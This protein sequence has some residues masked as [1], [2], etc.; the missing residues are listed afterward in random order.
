MNEFAE[1]IDV[2]VA[3][4]VAFSALSDLAAM[5][6]WSPENTGGHWLSASGPARGARFRG[7]NERDGSAWS[8]VARVT[9]Y[10]PPAHFAFEVT[11]RG[12]RVSRWEYDVAPTATGC[13]ITESWSDRRPWI[14]RGAD[15]RNGSQRAAFTRT[16]VH[17][18]LARLKD[19]LEGAP[20]T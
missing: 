16:S 1:S 19:E 12:L 13:R 9:R 2:A 17:T 5:G 18:T 20:T 3:P 15:D 7:T 11:F 6:R 4:A 8:T 10:E 14:L